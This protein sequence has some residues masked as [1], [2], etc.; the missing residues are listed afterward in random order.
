MYGTDIK[1]TT[2]KQYINYKAKIL[3]DFGLTNKLAVKEHLAKAVEGMND[4]YRMENKI[5]RVA[6][7]MIMQFLDGNREFC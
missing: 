7:D 5:D 6:Q 1:L 2:T 3:K 4:R